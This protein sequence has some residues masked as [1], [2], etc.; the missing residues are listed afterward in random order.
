VPQLRDALRSDLA[1][2]VAIYNA[3]IPGRRA[4]ADLDPVSVASRRAWFDAHTPERYP[5]WVLESGGAIAGWLGF[6][7]FY[8]RPA[9]AATAELGVY[10]APELQRK[11][12]ASRLLGAA[13]SRAPGLGFTTLLGFIF[14]HNDPSLR[15]FEKFGFEEWGRLPRVA[16]LD[17]VERDL[18]ILGRRVE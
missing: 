13:V 14:G 8:G 12:V 1:R 17:G 11:G 3:S 6:S 5:L 9:Y 15:L 2:I 4:T 18:F 10:V 16:R 7:A